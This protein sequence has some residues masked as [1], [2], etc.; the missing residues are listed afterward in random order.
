MQAFKL[1]I[2]WQSQKD[3]IHPYVEYSYASV[4]T[5]KYTE[6]SGGFPARFDKNKES[7]NDIRIGFDSNFKLNEKNKIITSLEGYSPY[8]KRIKWNKRNV[9]RL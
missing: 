6:T 9:N 7:T 3:Y 8:G 1:R 2:Q 4:T 5:D